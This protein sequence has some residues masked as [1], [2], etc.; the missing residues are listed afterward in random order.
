MTNTNKEP[1]LTAKHHHD[2]VWRTLGLA[3]PA[4]RALV[5]QHCYTLTDLTRH[6]RTAVAHW[7]GIGPNALTVL[8]QAL[9][10]AEL[11]FAGE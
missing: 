1:Q 9:H 2:T 5:A 8:D 10:V 7:H 6:R 11:A 3:A 4:R